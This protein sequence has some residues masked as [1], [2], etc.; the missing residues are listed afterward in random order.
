MQLESTRSFRETYSL[1]SVIDL[2]S[3]EVV[4]HL[5]GLAL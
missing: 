5:E 4:T 1:R 2:L 3:H